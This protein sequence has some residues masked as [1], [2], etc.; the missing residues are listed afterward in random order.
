MGLGLVSSCKENGN[1]KIAYQFT[2]MLT[3]KF[4]I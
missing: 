3:Q 4:S 2:F 1:K